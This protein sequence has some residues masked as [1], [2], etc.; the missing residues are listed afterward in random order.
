MIDRT[1]DVVGICHQPPNLRNV[2][3]SRGHNIFI[4]S[5]IVVCSAVGLLQPQICTLSIAG[6]EAQNP[7]PEGQITD[8][9][10][11]QTGRTRNLYQFLRRRMRHSFYRA[12]RH[13]RASSSSSS[14]LP[15]MTQGR[16][17]GDADSCGHV[18]SL[19]CS[20]SS[21]QFGHHEA[22]EGRSSPNDLLLQ[23]LRDGPVT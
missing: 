21:E 5:L 7:T 8:Y 12:A 17:N 20:T 14:M 19:I 15:S 23:K 10:S 11:A 9:T 3:L 18:Y 1:D 4:T 6:T 16:G 22:C 2:L 13:L